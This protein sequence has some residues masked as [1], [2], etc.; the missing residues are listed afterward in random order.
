MA[1]S[2]EV[3]SRPQ[4]GL[5]AFVFCLI[6]GAILVLRWTVFAPDPV[7]VRTDPRHERR[8][9]DTVTNS[10]AGTI[11][12]RRRAFVTA[13]MGGRVVEVVHSEGAWVEKGAVLLRLADAS[14]RAQ[15]EL[16]EQG[17]RVSQARHD[18]ACLRRDRAGRELG[19]KRKLATEQI[20]SED[21]LDELQFAFESARVSCEAAS[22]ELLRSRASVLGAEADLQ[23]T[24]ILAPFAGVVAEVSTEVGEWVT[25]SPPLLTSPPVVDL[26]DPTSLYISAPMDE[27]DSS[28]I[29]PNQRV[30]VTVD[31]RPGESFSGHV[32][33][34]APYVKTPRRRTEPS[35]SRSS[36]RILRTWPGSC[37]ERRPM[38]RSC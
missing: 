28:R 16:A 11:R 30:V 10:K 1:A 18:E 5:R 26:I 22:A 35:R 34:V 13:E 36:S 25:P 6:V 33:R 21:L 15:L 27:V 8:V 9:A 24:M 4:W 31:S 2:D 19:R 7:V 20:V 38:W 14:P 37:R 17:V 12:A 29:R 23:K 32:H 3:S